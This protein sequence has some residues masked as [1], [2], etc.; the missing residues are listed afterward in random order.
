M[1]KLL[2]ILAVATVVATSTA[3]ATSTSTVTVPQG[4]P[5]QIA[6]VLPFSQ[7]IPGA[8][9]AANAVQWAVDRHAAIDGFAVQVNTYDAICGPNGGPPGAA[10]AQAVISNTQNVAVIGHYCGSSEAAAL[11]YYENAGLTTISGSLTGELLP[12]FGPTVFN[13]TVVDDSP[14]QTN[15]P[16]DSGW[17]RVVQTLPG[18][19]A[20]QQAYTAQ[21][22]QSP[23][24]YAD[25]YYDATSV[26]LQRIADVATVDSNGSL[27]IGRAA[28]AAAVRGTTNFSGVSCSVSFDSHGNRVDDKSALAACRGS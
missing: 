12:S 7:G 13:R 15:A 23:A 4:Q 16:P 21:F 19:K 11:P 28:L 22:G 2:V 25:L 3:G 14:T 27:V 24:A 20:W 26:L 1:R 5:I 8:L 9:S 18:D 17:Y 10:A 6:L